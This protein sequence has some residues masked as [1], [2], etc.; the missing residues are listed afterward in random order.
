MLWFQIDLGHSYCEQKSWPC[1]FPSHLLTIPKRQYKK[2]KKA[3]E[4]SHKKFSE[5]KQVHVGMEASKINQTRCEWTINEPHLPYKTGLDVMQSHP[6]HRTR[7][8]QYH[9]TFTPSLHL[10]PF[11]QLRTPQNSLHALSLFHMYWWTWYTQLCSLQSLH[12]KDDSYLPC[13][14]A[15]KFHNI[16]I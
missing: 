10:V 15:I 5:G 12:I 13:S 11:F 7:F 3:I 6:L 8:G 1:V 2:E 9:N 16:T 14:A 4:T